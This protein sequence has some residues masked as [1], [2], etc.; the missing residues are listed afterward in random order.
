MLTS[1]NISS[2]WPA[3]E[4][5]R[6]GELQFNDNTQ[7]EPAWVNCFSANFINPPEFYRRRPK[8]REGWAP[9]IYTTV[10]DAKRD[11]PELVA[12]HVREV[13]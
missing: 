7:Q 4:A 5:L 11:Y 3:L 6:D 8:P 13:L 2:Y 10:E 9:F 1:E 12:Y